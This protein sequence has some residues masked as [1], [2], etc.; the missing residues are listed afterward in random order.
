MPPCPQ[1]TYDGY[2]YEFSTLTA[3]FNLAQQNCRNNGGTLARY[4]DEDAYLELRKCCQNGLE[5]WIGLFENRD[6]SSSSIG[7]YSWVGNATCTSG[8]PLNVS[9][10]PNTAQSSQ[11]VAIILSNNLAQPPDANERYDSEAKV[12]VCQ[13]PLATSTTAT[14]SPSFA[15]KADTSLSAESTK[16]I[17]KSFTIQSQRS[18]LSS[19]STFKTSIFADGDSSALIAG[20]VAGG[21]ILIIALLLFYF[22]M[23]K[24]GCYKNFKNNRKHSN[25]SFT[26]HEDKVSSTNRKVKENPLYGRYER[27]LTFFLRISVFMINTVIS[28]YFCI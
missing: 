8:S 27:T 18:T 15:T 20:L 26:A 16:T 22:F 12:Y 25:A 3:N 24:N 7:P 23:H 28:W 14:S 2:Q 6:C 1:C 9:S 11:A 5:Y 21:I 10:V 19:T 4:L 17:S 13:Y